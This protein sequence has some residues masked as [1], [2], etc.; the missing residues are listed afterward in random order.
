MPLKNIPTRRRFGAL[1]REALLANPLLNFDRLLLIKRRSQTVDA[2]GKAKEDL[3]L[4]QNWQG[5]CVLRRNYEN[6]IAVLSPVRPDG[7][8]TT[9]FKPAKPVFVG[10]W[11]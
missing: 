1:Q 6:E 9:L 4:P 8:L 7:K 11:T 2:K 5:N 10:D 3:G